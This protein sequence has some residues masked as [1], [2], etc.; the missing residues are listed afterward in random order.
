MR[1]NYSPYLAVLIIGV[2]IMP[3]TIQAQVTL[4][5]PPKTVAL[6]T[7]QMFRGGQEHHAQQLQRGGFTAAT[8]V[9]K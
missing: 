1:K 5:V 7:W 6:S 4:P 3:V 9:L 2:S 8:P